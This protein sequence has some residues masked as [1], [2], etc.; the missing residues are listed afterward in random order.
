MKKFL[1]LFL[2]VALVMSL[3]VPAFAADY[4][5]TDSEAQTNL[6]FTLAGPTY[7]I[8]IPATMNL[9]VG[10]NNIP[11]TVSDMDNFS[12][13]KIVVTAK[14]TQAE[15]DIGSGTYFYDFHLWPNGTIPAMLADV[16]MYTVHRL[17]GTSDYYAISPSET[18]IVAE[19]TAN[20]TEN[21]QIT[22]MN[23]L[24]HPLGALDPIPTGVPYTG[25]ITFGISVE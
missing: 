1:T 12:G 2:A 25:W 20:G 10:N 5:E 21:V 18:H 9:S 13:E 8:T 23:Y 15:E 19:F 11:I 6:S 3:S 16:L 14:E 4:D 17:D 24:G 7:T 22:V